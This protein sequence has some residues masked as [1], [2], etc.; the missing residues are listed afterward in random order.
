M[1]WRNGL[2]FGALWSNFQGETGKQGPVGPAGPP[3]IQVRHLATQISCAFFLLFK[4]IKAQL[5]TLTMKC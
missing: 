4:K 1:M 2:T 5:D 3:G